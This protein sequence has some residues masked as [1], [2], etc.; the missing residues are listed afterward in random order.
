MGCG[1]AHVHSQ[2]SHRTRDVTN[3]RGADSHKHTEA[4]SNMGQDLGHAASS[5]G[6]VLAPAARMT[7]EPSSST[8]Q[9]VY[10]YRRVG[11]S[12]ERAMVAEPHRHEGWKGHCIEPSHARGSPCATKTSSPQGQRSQGIL[13]KNFATQPMHCRQLTLLYQGLPLRF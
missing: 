6:T 9:H 11:A 1:G 4:A 13:V 10:K 12:A 2:A 3:M 8:S 7:Q 5:A